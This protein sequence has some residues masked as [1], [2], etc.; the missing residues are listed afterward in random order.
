MGMAGLKKKKKQ[1]F[2]EGQD[3]NWVTVIPTILY[4]PKARNKGTVG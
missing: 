3:Q 1:K 2:P 4:G